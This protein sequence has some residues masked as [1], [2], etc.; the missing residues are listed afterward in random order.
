MYQL[1]IIIPCYNEQNSINQ[2]VECCYLL[3]KERNDIQ[4]LFV[5][6]GSRDKTRET[7]NEAIS[8]FKFTNAEIVEVPVNKG[9]GFGI[10][11]GLEASKSPIVAWTHADLQTD[12][13]DVILAYDMYKNELINNEII[14][15]GERYKRP[16]FDNLFTYIMSHFCS[17][18]LGI[19]LYD[20]N[21]QP[22]IFNKVLM[23]EMHDGPNDFLLDLYFLTKV[24]KMGYKVKTIPVFF[25]LRLYG[26]AKGAGS[27]IG[28]FKI[29]Y[30]T[31]SYTFNLN[32]KLKY[33]N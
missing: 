12:P 9:Y 7:L 16:L 20:I 6:N 32:K 17:I 11:C 18:I 14:V 33:L 19:K 26:N 5:N 30:K 3:V 1:S 25:N 22:K 13:K 8:S 2:L 21:A 29:S 24:I 15:K 27:I 4:F 10:K 31:I 28:K 23:K